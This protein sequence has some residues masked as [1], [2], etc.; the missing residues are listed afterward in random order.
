MLSS[1]SMNV[2]VATLVVAV[3]AMIVVV[4]VTTVTPDSVIANPVLLL[5]VLI[6][7]VAVVVLIV[8]TSVLLVVSVRRVRVLR[9]LSVI[10]RVIAAM[11]LVVTRRRCPAQCGLAK[12]SQ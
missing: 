10:L 11:C 7:V 9:N 12:S 2:A 4:I 3:G 5:I 6:A 1:A 8:A